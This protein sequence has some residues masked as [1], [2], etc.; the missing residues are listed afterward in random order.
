MVLLCYT[1]KKNS[2]QFKNFLYRENVNGIS[3]DIYF[4]RKKK[5]KKNIVYV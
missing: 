5:L 3:Y 4:K 2:L 1:E